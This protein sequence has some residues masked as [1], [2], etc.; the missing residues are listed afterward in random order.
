MRIVVCVVHHAELN[1]SWQ[2]QRVRGQL[3]HRATKTEASDATLPLPGICVTALR[4]RQKDQDASR[5]AAD[6]WPE[7]GLGFTTLGE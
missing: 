6:H 4:V 3:L 2:L 1:I 7:T 5:V